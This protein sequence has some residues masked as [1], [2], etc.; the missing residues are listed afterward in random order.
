MV[1]MYRQAIHD[2]LAI[3]PG[4]KLARP[5]PGEKYSGKD[6]SAGIQRAIGGGF[7]QTVENVFVDGDLAT[8]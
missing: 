1:A 8:G 2:S 6:K 3:C 4:D 7:A 5:T